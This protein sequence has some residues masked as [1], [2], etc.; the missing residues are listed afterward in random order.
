MDKNDKKQI[1]ML[2]GF[3]IGRYSDQEIPE[4]MES[5]RTALQNMGIPTKKGEQYEDLFAL[6]TDYLEAMSDVEEP[7]TVATE[8]DDAWDRAM[9]VL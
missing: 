6:L 4:T 9:K 7:Q 8:E 5:V 2:A 3:V 1:I